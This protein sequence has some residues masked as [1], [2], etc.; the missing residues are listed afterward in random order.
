[1]R[2]FRGNKGAQTPAQLDPYARKRTHMRHNR[3]EPSIL[4]YE[5]G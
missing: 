5:G 4:G 3:V 1:M 2:G